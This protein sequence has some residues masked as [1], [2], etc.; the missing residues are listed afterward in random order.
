MEHTRV[1]ES[2]ISK[3]RLNKRSLVNSLDH[4]LKVHIITN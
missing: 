3:E 2:A 1:L 4:Y